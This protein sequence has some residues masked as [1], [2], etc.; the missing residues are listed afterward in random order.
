MYNEH[1]P[2]QLQQ[3][4]A[5]LKYNHRCVFFFIVFIVRVV[6]KERGP[7]AECNKKTILI[8]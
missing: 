4:N 6:A 1:G 2:G 3:R 7:N 8:Q 5:C